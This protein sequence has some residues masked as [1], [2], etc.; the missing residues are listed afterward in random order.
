MSAIIVAR[1]TQKNN[2][3]IIQHLQE[4]Y[5]YCSILHATIAHETTS[6]IIVQLLHAIVVHKTTALYVKNA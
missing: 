2:C 3:A 1:C 5:D 4:F 6:E